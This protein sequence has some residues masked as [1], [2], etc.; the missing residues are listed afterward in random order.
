MNFPYL[1]GAGLYRSEIS[2]YKKLK[3][4]PPRTVK[5]YEI[6]LFCENYQYGIVDGVQVP[7]HKGTVL[8]AKPGNVRCSRFHFACYYLHVTV[9]DPSMKQA[10][11]ELPVSLSVSDEE[12]Y[13]G[14]FRRIAALFPETDDQAPFEMTGLLM[15]LIARLQETHRMNRVSVRE[16]PQVRRDAVA[17]AR[18]T[19]NERYMQDLSLHT[20]AES[21]HLNPNYFHKLFT[22]VCGVTPLQYLTDVRISHAKYYLRNTDH[23]ITEIAELCGFGSYTYFCTVFRKLSGMSP[24]IFRQSAN[25]VYDMAQAIPHDS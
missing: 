20:L 13:I 24:S 1:S 21:V 6:E 22:S 18:V 25:S 9:T 12:T 23:S 10:L 17:T 15:L 5:E 2:E 16:L 14:L 11:D 8:I 4:S 19:I 7:Y 3:M